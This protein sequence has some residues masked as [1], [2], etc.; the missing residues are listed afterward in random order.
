MIFDYK[1]VLIMGYGESGKAVEKI[2][3]DLNINHKIYDKAHGVNGGGYY[4]TLSRKK[5]MQF[6]LIV[7]SPGVSIF[8]KY[9]VMAEKMGIKVVGELEFG[10]WFTS[11]PV[12]AIT[13]TNGKTT[14]TSLI[15]NIIGSTYNSGAFGNIGIPLCE[16]YKKQF[17]YLVCEVSSFQLE[18]TYSFNPYISVLLNIAEDHI[19]R[20][21]NF[22]N[23]IKCKLGLIKNC[24]EKSIIVLS[25]DDKILMERTENVKAKKY[26]ISK[27]NKVKG[28]YI[29]N[30]TIYVNLRNKP[31]KF[32]TLDEF[33][34]LSTVIEDVLASILVGMLMKIDKDKTVS[35]IKE[36]NMMPHRMKLV[37]EKNGV[38]YID[39]SKS[40]NVHSTV[41]ALNSSPEGVVLLL[42]GEDKNLRFDEIFLKF[43]NKLAEV[44]A[45]GSARK[46]IL[47]SANKCG[48]E[49]IKMCKTFYEAVKT[50]Y[51]IAKEKNVVL[52]SPACASFDEFSSYAERG[53]R[54]EKIVK[55]LI[56]AKN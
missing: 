29:S 5:L 11:S 54:F 10:Y 7:I 8:N 19:D 46:K 50:A 22:E 32:A 43:S 27:F 35:A 13:G 31:E 20:H 56:D 16:A 14:T 44:V 21:K 9:V 28:V 6:D 52:L 12:I 1:N 15:N 4:N 26:Y 40:T 55:E 34:H 36:Y 45:F 18:S 33:E 41:N 47:K 30:E 39:D 37:L 24:T 23:Y 3:K 53:E 51:N 2:L 48:F 42:G 49:K 25:A 38:K 17:D